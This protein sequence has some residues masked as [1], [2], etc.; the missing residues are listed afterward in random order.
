MMAEVSGDT[1]NSSAAN[2]TTAVNGVSSGT[3]ILFQ[4][5]LGSEAKVIL[6]VQL[7]FDLERR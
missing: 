7:L 1:L 5:S 4:G 2:R 6:K 3:F